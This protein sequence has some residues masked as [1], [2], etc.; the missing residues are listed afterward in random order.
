MNMLSLI[1][2][3]IKLAIAGALVSLIL[4]A[5]LFGYMKGREGSKIEL[6]NIELLQKSRYQ[7]LRI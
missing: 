1:P 3:P 2:L 5:A 6:A 7:I 4:V